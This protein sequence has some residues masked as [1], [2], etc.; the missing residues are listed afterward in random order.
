MVQGGTFYNDAVL[1]SF[2]KVSGTK[3][4]RPD[5]AGIMGAFGAALIA[6]KH[7]RK[8][9]E[10]T[11]LSYEQIKNLSYETNMERCQKCNNHCML[12]V[13]TFTGGRNYISGNRYERGLGLEKNKD[14]IPNLF[15]YKMQR[16]FGYKSL[17]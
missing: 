2:E 16:I 11:T 13:N 9:D 6:R 12:T 14:N 8:G 7:Y 4:I 10:T 5:I 17:C 1:R 15:E 3:A